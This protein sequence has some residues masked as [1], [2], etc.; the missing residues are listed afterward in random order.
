LL[1]LEDIRSSN[2]GRLE[3]LE[4]CDAFEKLRDGICLEMIPGTFIMC[5][6]GGNFCC[7]MCNLSKALGEIWTKQK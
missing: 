2:C 4:L 1:N 7:Q 6:E 5:G 3:V